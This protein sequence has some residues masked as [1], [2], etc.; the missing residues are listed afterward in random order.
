[1]VAFFFQLTLDYISYCFLLLATCI[2]LDGQ[3]NSINDI[4]WSPV[5]FD[6]Y[7]KTCWGLCKKMCCLLCLVV[8]ESVGFSIFSV[9]LASG[10]WDFCQA[11]HCPH[12]TSWTYITLDFLPWS[13]I[14]LDWQRRPH[15]G[16]ILRIIHNSHFCQSSPGNNFLVIFCSETPNYQTTL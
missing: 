12:T 2:V 14:T 13:R 5:T 6:H 8:M 15:A 1:M 3:L 7:L 16:L 10:R 4:L 9:L 11:C